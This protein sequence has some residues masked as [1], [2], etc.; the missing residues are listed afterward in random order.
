LGT[1]TVGNL[2]K[3]IR[4]EKE[5]AFDHVPP[6]ALKLWKVSASSFLLFLRAVADGAA[7]GRL[8]SI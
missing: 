3:A 4:K 7:S 5:P 6:D 8:T 2:K 1:K